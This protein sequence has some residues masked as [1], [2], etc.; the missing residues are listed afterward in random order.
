VPEVSIIIPCYNR[1]RFV[2]EAIESSLAQG[3]SVEVIVVDDGSYDGSWDVISR[4]PSVRSIRTGNRG[5]SAARNHG[6]SMARGRFIRFQDSD[7]RIPDGA[8]ASMLDSAA[9]LS[10]R[11]IAAGDASVV[12]ENDQPVTDVAYGFAHLAPPGP[13]S[14][15]VLFSGVMGPPLPLFPIQALTDVGGFNEGL[16]ISEDFELASRLVAAGYE[17]VRIPHLVCAVREHR[18]E[19][20][21]RDQSSKFYQQ[22]LAA[23][24]TSLA[25]LRQ[26]GI[27]EADVPI[28]TRAWTLGRNAVRQG[29]RIEATALFD[30][31]NRI[32][33]SRAHNAHPLLKAAY[34]VIPAAAVEQLSE[35]GKSFL[36]LRRRI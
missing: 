16:V 33:G 21:S 22:Q 17:F 24:E 26:A 14:L 13:L 5:P 9:A 31:A 7:D 8:I 11:Q 4:Y 2:A 15:A 18:N 28:A 20:L 10:S 27:Q 23:L 3:P 19:R 30:F 6:L 36:Q 32:A 1:E 35:F 25:T 29:Y 12:D 34:R